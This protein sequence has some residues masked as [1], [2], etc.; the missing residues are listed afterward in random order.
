MPPRR[1]AAVKAAAASKPAAKAKPASSAKAK[2]AG[3]KRKKEELSDAEEA[4]EEDDGGDAPEPK[5]QKR[6]TAKVDE[7]SGKQATHVVYVDK[8][9]EIYDA[10]LNQ[11]NISNNNNKF[12]IV[13]LLAPKNSNATCILFTRWGRVGE[14]GATQIKGPWPAAEAEQFFKDQFK[15]KSGIQFE[16]RRTAAPKASKYTWIDLQYEGEEEEEVAAAIGNGDTKPKVREATP[17]SQLEKPVKELVEFIFNPAYIQNHLGH[18]NYDAHKLPLGKLSK[19]TVR[20]GY[21]ALKDIADAIEAPSKDDTKDEDDEDEAPA[22]GRGRKRTGTSKKP[23]KNDLAELSSRF[24]TLIPHDHGRNR[25]PI[26]NTKEMV[27]RESDLIDTLVELEETKDLVGGKME[28]KKENPTDAQLNS[29]GLDEIAHLDHSSDEFKNLESYC[30][31]TYLYGNYGQKMHIQEIF[32]VERNG[33]RDRWV[34]NKWDDLPD[35][36]GGSRLLLFHGSRSTNFGGI[37]KNGLK[38]APPEAPHNGYAYGKG[39]YF[40]DMLKLSAGYTYSYLSDNTGLVLLC[41]VAAKPYL[42]RIHSTVHA[43]EECKKAE[44]TL[45]KTQATDHEA[46]VDAG[47][48]TNNAR[49]DGVL[50]PDV[51]KLRDR[52]AKSQTW[53]G[54]N[55]FVAY[56]VSQVRLRYLIRMK[57]A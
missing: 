3:S 24:Y 28:V 42:H 7:F 16:Q 26:I 30:L 32:R 57:F 49:L 37:L 56:D 45:F 47:K 8:S 27:K 13:Q 19:D 25:P 5:K 14:N 23:T 18:F 54:D 6:G 17:N 36:D 21:A 55:M 35:I 38:I 52:H 40:A 2:A 44:K 53:W 41:E 15:S 46:W 51:S 10:T 20:R 12:Y 39:L 29:L 4:P 33:E 50:M 1:A 43:A 22:K 48:A 31:E 9:G 34:E 11:T